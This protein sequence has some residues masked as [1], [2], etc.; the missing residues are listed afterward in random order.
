MEEEAGYGIDDYINILRYRRGQ[1]IVPLVLI[2]CTAVAAAILIP[3]KYLSEATILIEQQEIPQDLVRSTVTS[4]ADQRVQAISQRVLNT[5]NLGAVIEKFDLYRDEREVSSL[6]TVVQDMREDIRLDMV[7]AEVVDPRS[8][9]PAEATIAFG[10]SYESKSPTLAQKVANE[11]VTL[12]LNENV[13]QRRAVAQEASDFLA[14]EADKLAVQ[15]SDLEARLALFKEKYGDSLP[16]MK[17]L[18]M[19]LLQRADEQI[20]QNEQKISA[21]E[22]RIVYLQSE[23]AQM[24]PQSK[25]FSS[26]G[27]RVLSP[28]DQLQSLESEYISLASRYGEN[29]PDRQRMAREIE[30]LRREVGGANVA[31]QRRQ[32]AELENELITLRERYSNEHPDIKRQ[33]RAIAA[34]RKQLDAA[35]VAGRN[36]APGESSDA[37]NPAYIQLQAQLQGARTELRSLKTLRGELEKKLSDYE[38]RLTQGPKIEREYLTLTRDYDNAQSKYREVRAKQLEAELAESLEVESKAERFVLIEPPILPEKPHSPNRMAI[39]FLGF[40]LSLGGG[41]GHVFVREH[42]DPR[43]RGV[44]DLLS[45]VGVPPLTI[46]PYVETEAEHTEKRRWLLLTLVLVLVGGL[47]VIAAVH[48]FVKPLDVAWYQLMYRLGWVA[49]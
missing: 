33:Q 36:R 14:V 15:I 45:V 8:G 28:E 27:E 11:V 23:L 18:N 19:Q 9:R 24:D 6:A 4:Y 26:T 44:K 42:L 47:C 7:S 29:H 48:F 32:L 3:A 39:L 22:E 1:L 25:L 49:I 30:A 43:V 17:T 5:A 35:V 46:I 12:F 41:V 2:F 40:V 38:S 13:K 16:E 21:T 34:A 31:D 10:L 20:L 37:D